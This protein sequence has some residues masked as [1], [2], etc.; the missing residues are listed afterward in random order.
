MSQ[1][2]QVVETSQHQIEG[3]A[4]LDP[5]STF[6]P[7]KVLPPK[8]RYVVNHEDYQMERGQVPPPPDKPVRMELED[9][10]VMHHRVSRNRNTGSMNSRIRP[11]LVTSSQ[12]RQ[13]P[14][15]KKGHKRMDQ[16]IQFYLPPK[17]S[18]DGPPK[19]TDEG[20][21]LPYIPPS[22]VPRTRVGREGE[23]QPSLHSSLPEVL[24]PSIT[25]Q[26]SPK[27]MS[28]RHALR[29]ADHEIGPRTQPRTHVSCSAMVPA[30]GGGWKAEEEKGEWGNGVSQRAKDAKSKKVRQASKDAQW[31]L[32]RRQVQM[33]EIQRRQKAEHHSQVEHEAKSRRMQQA[34]KKPPGLGGGL[35]RQ[36]TSAGGPRSP[37][38]KFRGVGKLV[39]T[40]SRSI[41]QHVGEDEEH[42]GLPWHIIDSIPAKEPQERDVSIWV[43]PGYFIS[44]PVLDNTK[45][46]E[47]TW[48][49]AGPI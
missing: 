49:Q 7:A 2:P 42:E 34:Q 1:L 43:K 22:R 17:F 21:K 8:E 33:K 30:R 10:E 45:G 12:V 37:M 6:A 38:D 11:K 13:S 32:D 20:V 14:V 36:N 16:Q 47:P 41:G 9:P 25:G 26:V 19:F 3:I 44:R 29:Q 24:I 18:A 27:R 5:N 15:S 40:M 46:N 31:I 23:P 39:A 4:A 28:D 48:I 35:T